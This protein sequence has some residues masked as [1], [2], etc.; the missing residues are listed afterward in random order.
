MDRTGYVIKTPKGETNV[1]KLRLPEFGVVAVQLKAGDKFSKAYVPTGAKAGGEAGT[2]DFHFLPEHETIEIHYQINNPTEIVKGAR[3]QLYTRFDTSPLFSLDLET[4][5]TTWIKHGKHVV[6]WDGRLPAAKAVMEGTYDKGKKVWNHDLTRFAEDKTQKAFP[7]GY[8]TL[9]HTPYKLKLTLTSSDA[10]IK[11]KPTTGWTYFHILLKKIEFELGEEDTI[12]KVGTNARLALDKALRAKIDSDGGIPAAGATRKLVL[13]SNLYKVKVTTGESQMN[14][15][16]AYDVFKDLWGDGPNIPIV[17]KIRLADSTDAEIKIDEVPK[18]AVAL[19]NV[20]F[21][22]DWEDPAEDVSGRSQ[23]AKAT[24]FI[25]D[26]INYYKDGTDATRAA[27]NHTY[28]KGDNSHVDRGGKR[29]PDAKPVFP[30]QA[31]YDPKDTLETGKFPFKVITGGALKKR[32]WASYSHAWTKGKLKGKTGVVFQPSRMG[33]D[34]YTLN[35]YLA[36]DKSKK[37]EW[38]LDAQDE[39]LQVPAQIKASTGKWQMWREVHV[40]RYVRKKSTIL[41]PNDT[42]S[43]FLPGSLVDIQKH[44]DMAYMVLVDKMNG[45]DHNYI[46]SDHRLPGGTAPNYNTLLRARLTGT[47]NV[48]FTQNLATSSSA[49]HSSVDSMI[50]VRTYG[51]FVTRVH[52]W[53]HSGVAAAAN[54]FTTGTPAVTPEALGSTNVS[55][56]ASNARNNRLKSTRNWLMVNKVD[57]DRKYCKKMDDFG[58]GIG[59]NFGSDLKLLTG[60]KNGVGKAAPPGVTTVNFNYTNTALRDRIKAGKAAS[61]WYGAA[62]DATD[63]DINHCLIMYWRA[64]IERFSH[65]FGH[66]LFL[67]HAKYPTSH[68]PGGFKVERHDDTDSGCMMSYSSTRPGFCGLCQLRMRGWDA[69]PLAT[70]KLSKISANNKKP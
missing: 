8:V 26:A 65:E 21:M 40:A 43:N 46:L 55:G 29:G 2:D 19:G 18:G 4:L 16:K 12:P 58:I 70:P 47:G 17:A 48:L 7:D 30:A 69:G 14:T 45:T 66:H 33:G 54:D 64:G 53:F 50:L 11:G 1:N 9:E 68:Q 57:T 23:T 28:P 25:G 15:N 56:W 59:E 60:S 6:K 36:Y 3:L 49:D 37:D 32:K 51:T 61:Y 35:V 24:T 34:D 42:G 13:I 39:P 52:R 20:R 31:G 62:V 10:E 22:W 5:G 27:K 63:A 44:F 67:P 41:F 38:V